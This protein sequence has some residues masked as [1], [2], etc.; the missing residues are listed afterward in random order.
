MR[1]WDVLISKG[2]LKPRKWYYSCPIKEYTEQG[3]LERYWIEQ[4]CLISNKNCIRYQMKEGGKDY[5]ENMLPN[6]AISQK[7]PYDD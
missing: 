3:K 5:P 4:Y 1:G 2:T 6:G 7:V